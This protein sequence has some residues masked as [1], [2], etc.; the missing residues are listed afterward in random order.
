MLVLSAGKLSPVSLLSRPGDSG[1]RRHFANAAVIRIRDIQSCAGGPAG[2]QTSALVAIPPSPLNPHLP[3]P[4]T[5]E[6]RPAGSTMR[7][8]FSNAVRNVKIAERIRGNTLKTI[9][10]GGRSPNAI[11]VIPALT[12]RAPTM[13]IAAE[14][15][16]SH[17]TQ[18]VASAANR[19]RSI[20]PR[21]CQL[22]K[23]GLATKVVMVPAIHLT[24]EAVTV[25][26]MKMLVSMEN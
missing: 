8:R 3:S 9:Q 6:M 12:G 24:I 5:V 26:A 1:A 25:S 22:Q 10:L 14:G 13:L 7:M 17:T 11:P 20:H 21:V 15:V 16:I 2:E 4:V 23:L 19:F 18:A